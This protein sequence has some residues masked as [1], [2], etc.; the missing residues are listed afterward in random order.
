MKIIREHINEKFVED[1]DPIRDLGIGLRGH[2][3]KMTTKI[4]RMTTSDI[5]SKYFQDEKKYP[6]NCYI[7]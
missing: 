6:K 1:S 3:E 2:W 4:G 5:C 7:V